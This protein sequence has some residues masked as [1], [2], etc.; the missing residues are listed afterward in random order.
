MKN[1][2]NEEKLL[3]KKQT[4]KELK[5]LDDKQAQNLS[6]LLKSFKADPKEI[7]EWLMKCDLNKLSQ[8]SLEQLEKFLP[9][10]T[11]LAK[12]QE[13]KENI[14]DLDSSE[15]FLVIISQ[16]KGLRK[17]IKSLIFKCKFPEQQDEIRVDLVAGTQACIDV[18]NS[19]K[20]QKLL[21][22]FLLVGNFLNS[23]SSSLE[24][25]IGFDM[26][27][28]PKFFG[29]KANDNKRTLLHLVSQ[30]IT[31]KHPQIENFYDDFNAFLEQA[32]KI[33]GPI[34]QK[35]L[36]EMKTSINNLELD[37]KNFKNRL[38]STD[39]YLEVMETFSSDARTRYETLDCMFNK[40]NDC[41]KELAEFYTFDSSKYPLGEFFTDLKTFC[42]QFE[43]CLNDNLKFR[44]TEEK[45]RRAEEERKIRE[46]EKQVRKAQKEK[47]IKSGANGGDGDTGVMDNLLEALQSGKIF[48]ATNPNT[49]GPGRRR[50]MR[51][52]PNFMALCKRGPGV[53]PW[54]RDSRM[55]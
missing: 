54:L 51:R 42:H 2:D 32:S 19:E 7:F 44:E 21:E 35:S 37:I 41:Y 50:P 31:E 5:Y 23:G 4:A 28:L 40:M 17:R 6:I 33:D 24:G 55:Y 9:D 13:L 34:I 29:T 11:T 27:Y 14:D 16:I 8:S 15:K 25:S 49:N 1:D 20:F 43:Q 39:K 36:N 22:V 47:F 3:K 53:E 18:K 52:N 12:Y 26:K 45:I 10:D 46:K 48:E 38:D 30:I